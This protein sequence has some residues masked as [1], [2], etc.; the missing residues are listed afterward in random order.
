MDTEVQWM[1][2][3]FLRNAIVLT[4]EERL[5]LHRLKG[6]IDAACEKRMIDGPAQ[7]V[8]DRIAE[9]MLRDRRA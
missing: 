2:P 6:C 3:L 5:F 4:L 1:P 8:Y 7:E 9:K